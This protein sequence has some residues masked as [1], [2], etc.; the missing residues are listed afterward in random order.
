MDPDQELLQCVDPHVH[1]PRE[2]TDSA[3]ELITIFRSREKQFDHSHDTYTMSLR[4]A[5]GPQIG[6]CGQP[7]SRTSDRDGLQFAATKTGNSAG[8]SFDTFLLRLIQ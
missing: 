4:D 6:D 5:S 1:K 8:E 3:V 2:A 7:T